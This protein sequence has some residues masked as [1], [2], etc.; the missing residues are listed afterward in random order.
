MIQH[1]DGCVKRKEGK[2]KGGGLA[3]LTQH[4][5]SATNCCSY[6][7]FFLGDL[8]SIRGCNLHQTELAVNSQREVQSGRSRHICFI[9]VGGERSLA[10]VHAAQ[11]N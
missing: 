4:S 3:K 6:L 5:F 8:A 2:G 1:T 9:W 11:S 7:I 10:V